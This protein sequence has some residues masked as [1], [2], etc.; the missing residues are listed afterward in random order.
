MENLSEWSFINWWAVLTS[1]AIYMGFG[2]IW[3]AKP[4]FGA[5][6]Q[7]LV[8]VS[9]ADLLKDTPK[10][11]IGG[12]L[13]A[14]LIATGLAYGMEILALDYTWRNGLWLALHVGVGFIAPVIF[15]NVLFQ[16]KPFRLFLIDAGYQ[17]V[18]VAAMA[19]L[20]GSWEK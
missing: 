15:V 17:L 3:Y 7:K 10:T 14:G 1:I 6:W 2:A 9:D 16:R 12:A 19:I 18:T 11:M 4:V 5:M 20:I 13:M 8:G